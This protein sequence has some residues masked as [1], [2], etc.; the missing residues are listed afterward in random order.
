MMNNLRILIFSLGLL[1][2]LQPCL[3]AE[4]T[5]E[6]QELPA[7]TGRQPFYVLTSGTAPANYPLAIKETHGGNVGTIYEFQTKS[8][9]YTL[10]NISD[11]QVTVRDV[12]S[13][14]RC[15]QLDTPVENRILLPN[16]EL[17]IP[18]TIDGTR[19]KEG[20]FDRTL[21]VVVKDQPP[22]RLGVIGEL[23]PLIDFTPAVCINFDYYH[24]YIPFTRTFVIKTKLDDSKLQLSQPKENP[25]F[26]VKFTKTAPQTYTLEAT[27]KKRMFPQGRFA[28]K[29]EIPA[30]GIENYG[31]VFVVLKGYV[32]LPRLKFDKSKITIPANI[33]G[34]GPYK[35]SFEI[36]ASKNELPFRRPQERRADLVAFQP[37]SVEEQKVQTLKMVETWTQIANELQFNDLPAEVAIEKVPRADGLTITLSFPADFLKEMKSF[38]F[39]A[40]HGKNRIGNVQCLKTEQ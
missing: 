30:T 29:I 16:Q 14:C 3:T 23:V 27:A 36:L 40:K 1:L 20:K 12:K 34:N 31:P 35:A 15:I 25:Y 18:F 39:Y 17:P 32:A 11:R 37:V 26:D 24:G 38:M 5:N 4:E 28:E 22:V 9:V 10:K 2:L 21:M 8:V 6:E 33:Q 19:I 7:A 13:T